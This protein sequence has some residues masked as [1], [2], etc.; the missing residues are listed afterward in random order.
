MA[1]LSHPYMTTRKTNQPRG[2]RS[3]RASVLPGPQRRLRTGAS[4]PA[5]GQGRTERPSPG[6]SHRAK[7][8]P[9]RA[10]LPHRPP[11]PGMGETILKLLRAYPGSP[12]LQPRPG[13]P[14]PPAGPP[15]P[16]SPAGALSARPVCR[17][18]PSQDKVQATESLPQ[19]EPRTGGRHPRPHPPGAPRAQAGGGRGDRKSTRLNSSHTLASRMPSSA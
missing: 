6:G 16:P 17:R 2:Q 4:S 19:T 8:P 1:Q 10:R 14:F 13:T 18:R 3:L 7:Q 9:P 15:D 12:R 5:L 11:V